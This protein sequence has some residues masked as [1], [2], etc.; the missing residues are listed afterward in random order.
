MYFVLDKSI[1]YP[2]SLSKLF[3]Y[4]TFLTAKSNAYVIFMLHAL[5]LPL[6]LAL[7]IQ[8]RPICL[9]FIKRYLYTYAQCYYFGSIYGILV[10]IFRYIWCLLYTPVQYYI[11]FKIF[12]NEY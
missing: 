2:I 5:R 10:M 1:K 12:Q 6:F 7:S 3:H 11:T 4:F 8:G 9:Q